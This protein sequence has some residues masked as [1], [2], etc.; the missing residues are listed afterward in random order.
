MPH[1]EQVGAPSNIGRLAA[2]ADGGSS[3]AVAATDG[4]KAGAT[5][6]LAAG[7]AASPLWVR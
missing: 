4:G 7:K 2:L 1:S 5:A 6:T 3:S